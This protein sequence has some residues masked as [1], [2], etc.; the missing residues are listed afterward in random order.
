MRRV[1][2]TGGI[3]SGKSTVAR[4]LA[5]H[6]AHVVDADAVARD[7]VAPGTAGLARV[8]AT[9]PGVGGA[10]GALNRAA[11]AARVFD[12]PAARRRLEE[13]THPLNGAET[14]RRVADVPADGVFVH[15]VPLLVELGLAP[16]YDLVMVVE[17]PVELRLR[18]LE[19]RGL[20]ERQARER[21]A[22]QATDGQRRAVADVLLDNAGGQSELAGQVRRLWGERLAPF[23]AYA[24]AGQPAPRGGPVLVAYDPDWPRQA[25]RLVGRLGRVT[26]G[27]R[28]EHIGSTAVPGLAAKDVLDLQ[29][30]VSSMAEAD[31]LAASLAEAGFPLLPAIT[32]DTPK[33]SEPDPDRWRK[34]FHRSS[35]P[36]RPVNLH[37]REVG[38]AGRRFALAFRDWLRAEPAEL[39]AYQA[40]KRRVAAAH[41]QDVH[42]DGYAE[43]KEAW[44]AAAFPRLE[45]WL[46]ATGWTAPGGLG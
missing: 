28:A 36:G 13:I 43:G 37:V 44:F 24:A 30:V 4:L 3:G 27:L 38:S 35:D 7:V 18:R 10:D 6:G 39:A 26:G 46:A 32:G 42:I 14:A 8:L 21:I 17:S 22:A 34:R 9:F 31:G 11:L 2:L 15:D 20:A 29:L 1:G 33:A 41:A 23:A 16:A 40:E 19:H 45:T 5:G 25:E 12:D